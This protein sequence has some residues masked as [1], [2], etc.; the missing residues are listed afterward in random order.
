MAKSSDPENVLKI[1]ECCR[2]LGVIVTD[3]VSHPS[4]EGHAIN[5]DEDDEDDDTSFSIMTFCWR[6]VK[7]SSALL[8][9]CLQRIEKMDITLLEKTAQYLVEM[10]LKIRH[11]G[12]F[13]SLAKPLRDICQICFSLDN[14]ASKI[15]QGLLKE[16]MEQCV[17]YPEVQ[18]TR[19]SAGLPVCVAA[20]VTASKDTH[21][22][23]KLLGEAFETLL[24]VIPSSVFQLTSPDPHV[25]HTLNILRQLFRDSTLAED[26]TALLPTGFRLCFLAF[27]SPSWSVRNSG[28]MLFTA[29][30]N[31]TFGVRHDTEEYA[32]G[33][34]VDVRNLHAQCPS[35]LGLIMEECS[36]SVQMLGD[37]TCSRYQIEF[38]LYPLLSFIQRIRF[39]IGGEAR[40]GDFYTATVEFCLGCLG[41]D[42]MKV[43]KM[44]A[45]LVA[46]MCESVLI[47]RLVLDW[48][49]ATR[50]TDCNQLHGYLLLLRTLYDQKIIQSDVYERLNCIP[51]GLACYPLQQM[52][53]PDIAVKV[54]DDV[55]MA[56]II[57]NV[58]ARK[59]NPEEIAIQVPQL[60][61][62]AMSTDSSLFALLENFWFDYDLSGEY[63]LAIAKSLRPC[64][65]SSF[66]R[67]RYLA[68]TDDSYEI[69]QIASGPRFGA[70]A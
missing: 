34:L 47:K 35:I 46:N 70:L 50:E 24:S 37:S 14:E 40:H 60:V 10:L 26:V 17:L 43:R 64:A 38:A 15:P 28:M 51:E 57:E 62:H 68:L 7:E 61:E 45:R 25:V 52:V 49:E 54:E 42:I 3:F 29:L 20:I 18:T 16:A 31:R 9:S 55:P 8:A 41:K 53:S 33:N 6:A 11:P 27:G 63:R 22:R 23:C 39:S 48:I 65:H 32:K 36:K 21:R 2:Q 1:V 56:T 5:I 13:M 44:T 59:L 4:P 19:R 66:L 69:R 30:M 12:A 58:T 67:L